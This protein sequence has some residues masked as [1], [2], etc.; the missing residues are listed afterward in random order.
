[1][2]D[3]ASIDCPTGFT[4]YGEVKGCNMYAVQTEPAADI[5]LG[6]MVVLAG[7]SLK[8]PHMGNILEVA[9][10]ATAAAGVGLGVVLG[11]YDD[12]MAPVKYLDTADTGDGVIAG[13]VTVA[14]CGAQKYI[15]Q[16][17]GVTSSIVAANMGLNVQAVSTHAGD[18]DNGISGMEIDS[19]TI[20]TTVTHAFKLVAVH[21][22][23]TLSAS[24]D[25]GNHCRFIVM[26]NNSGLAPNVVG[27]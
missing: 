11:C 15:A 18:D 19:N 10:G 24:G 21:P 3:M 4:P 25:A 16:E 6:D 27:A 22:E 9:S 14:D 5:F 17:D 26:L 23:D 13:Y 2:A 8:T 7:N 1:M 12:T 20:A